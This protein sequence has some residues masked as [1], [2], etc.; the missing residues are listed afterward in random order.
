MI[1]TCLAA[2]LALLLAGAAHAETA[3]LVRN[4]NILDATSQKKVCY[5]DA[6]GFMY[7]YV[8]DRRLVTRPCVDSI[9]TP[10]APVPPRWAVL[11][12]DEMETHENPWR[13]CYYGLAYGGVEVDRI[14]IRESC[15]WTG[16]G[17]YVPPSPPTGTA[18]F[19]HEEDAEAGTNA[20]LCFYHLTGASHPGRFTHY[21]IISKYSKCPETF[22][23]R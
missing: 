23:A 6:G 4:P 18:A 3:Q 21:M 13:L 11:I 12:K 10:F 14:P 20:K 9:E 17:R 16:G 2:M 1:R 19:D 8:I 22:P 7:H 5:Y 15:G